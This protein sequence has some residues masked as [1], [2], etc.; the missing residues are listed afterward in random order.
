MCSWAGVLCCWWGGVDHGAFF[1]RA[2]VNAA[3]P[4]IR[5]RIE[6]RALH[7]VDLA[8]DVRAAHAARAIA[9]YAAP[10]GALDCSRLQ[11]AFVV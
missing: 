10:V 3:A 7:L 1:S 11:R 6:E 5:R 8:T 9:G 4:K 2:N